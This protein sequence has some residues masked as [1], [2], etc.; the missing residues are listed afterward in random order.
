MIAVSIV[1]VIRVVG[2]ILVIALMT[3]PPYI[4]E[5][6][7]VSLGQMMI[8]SSVLSAIFTLCGLWISY[9]FNITSGAAIILF[10]SV[11]F[12]GFHLWEKIM[13]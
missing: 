10:A 1:M 5:K 9:G 3:I 2:L 7:A 11:A 12:A 8:V 13:S 6:R 4:A